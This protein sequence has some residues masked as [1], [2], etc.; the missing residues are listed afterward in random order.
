VYPPQL[1]RL[2][3]FFGSNDVDI[4]R[5][6]DKLLEIAEKREKTAETGPGIA[7]KRDKTAETGPGIA[8]KRKNRGNQPRNRL[9]TRPNRWN[10]PRNRR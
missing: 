4:C 7:E 6:V 9:K 3:G 8:E 1:L 2:G 10:H 5:L